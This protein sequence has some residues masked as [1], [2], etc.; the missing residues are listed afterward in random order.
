MVPKILVEERLVKC[1]KIPSRAKKY[2]CQKIHF[3]CGIGILF[4]PY[5]YNDNLPLY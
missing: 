1:H 4:I 5:S 2:Y 3:F